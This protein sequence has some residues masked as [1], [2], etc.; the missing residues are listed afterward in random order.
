MDLYPLVE[1]TLNS[2]AIPYEPSKHTLKAWATYCLRDRG[3]KIIYA[4]NADFALDSRTEGKVY[5]S[6]TTDPD[7]EPKAQCAWILWSPERVRVIPPA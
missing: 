1:S 2:P 3:F 5:F 6:V 7:V 4:Q